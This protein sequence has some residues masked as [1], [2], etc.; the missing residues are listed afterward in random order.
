MSQHSAPDV[1]IKSDLEEWIQEQRL[2]AW[3]AGAE[4]TMKGIL[5]SS[6]IFLVYEQCLTEMQPIE[7]KPPPPPPRETRPDYVG[8]HSVRYQPACFEISPLTLYQHQ[9]RI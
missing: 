7:R 2:R 1:K 8:P 6:P 3:A 4:F 5:L 9:P